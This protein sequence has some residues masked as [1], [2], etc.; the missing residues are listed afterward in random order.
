MK[1]SNLIFVLIF[2]FSQISFASCK[3]PVTYLGLGE[4]AVCAG[5]L[6]SPEKE[7]EV[8]NLVQR[9]EILVEIVEKQ[10]R[11]IENLNNR[12]DLNQK[13]SQNLQDQLDNKNSQSTLEK[14]I[15]FTLGIALGV[16]ITKV[17][18]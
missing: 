17:L 10:E 9:Y 13:I 2:M 16:G 8:R 12:V 6:F 11:L 1:L 4:R 3:Q 14:I 5:Y 18:N 7:A 15:Y